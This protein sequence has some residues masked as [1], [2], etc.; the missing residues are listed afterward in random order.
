MKKSQSGGG[1]VNRSIGSLTWRE[2]PDDRDE[3]SLAGII[4][5]FTGFHSS[6]GVEGTKRSL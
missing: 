6:S 4:I 1:A 5:L 2:L 3:F